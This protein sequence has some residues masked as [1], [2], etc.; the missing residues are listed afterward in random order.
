MFEKLSDRLQ[1]SLGALRSRGKLSEADVDAALGE[2]RMALLEAD[3]GLEV[4]RDFTARVRERAVGAEVMKSLKPGH[5]VV[6][7][8]N[9]ELAALM[10]G[11]GVELELAGE[12]VSVVM[13]VG[14]QG[15]GKTTA[16]AKL[17]R[18]LSGQGRRV[19]LAA[20]DLQRPA[21]VEQLAKLGEQAGVTEYEQGAGGDPVEVAGWALDRASTEGRD[22]LIVDTAGRLHVDAELMDELVRVRERVQ[23]R[24]TLLVVDAMTG[25][26]AVNAA[27]SFAAEIGFDGI[28]LAKLDGDARGGAA[29]SVVA[30]TGRPILFASTGE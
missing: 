29:L 23:P 5:Q 27:Q 28:V 24:A 15:T 19:A 13:M 26:D 1:A 9:Q 2:V 11:T 22:T 18:Q 8:V 17:A 14:L 21:A 4:A 3:V 16:C 12:G 25:Q 7:I 10:G 6:K 30:V 20:C